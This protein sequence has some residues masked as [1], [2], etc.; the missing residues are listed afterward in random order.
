MKVYATILSFIALSGSAWAQ[1]AP[2]FCQS[3]AANAA[4][5]SDRAIKRNPACLDYS[6]GVHGNF[7]MHYDWCMRTATPSV[8][9]AEA[10]IRRLVTQCT[11]NAQPA[12]PQQAAPRPCN[13]LAGSYNRGASIITVTG[14][15]RVRAT[16]GPTRPAGTGSCQGSGLTVNFSDDRVVSGTF[17]GRTI[18]WSNRTTWTKD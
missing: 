14:G 12:R 11:G 7:K 4:G 5:M 17:N 1:N 15:N 18:V 16:V 13:G 2:G 10:N 6:K 9:G 8:H 3:Y